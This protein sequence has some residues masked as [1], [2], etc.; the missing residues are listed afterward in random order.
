MTNTKFHNT[1]ETYSIYTS[2]Y[3]LG[4]WMIHLESLH[5]LVMKKQTS[6]M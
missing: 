6:Q 1:K 2:S 4:H 5:S 3:P